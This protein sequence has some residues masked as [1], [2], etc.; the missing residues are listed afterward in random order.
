[1][2]KSYLLVYSN[3]L[4]TRDQVK[5]CLS[6]IKE[7][8]TWR[9][10]MPNSFYIISENSADEIARSIRNTLGK[11]RFILT[12]ISSNKQGWLPS[13]SWYLINNKKHKDK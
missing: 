7:V 8:L 11:G 5:N 13:E 4:G 9:F 1:M 3:S 6:S 10:D 2:R 12:E